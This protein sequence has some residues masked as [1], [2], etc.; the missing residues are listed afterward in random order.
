MPSCYAAREQAGKV[1]KGDRGATC[2]RQGIERLPIFHKWQEF[3]GVQEPETDLSKCP[4]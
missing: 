3:S 1:L 4:H 2:L